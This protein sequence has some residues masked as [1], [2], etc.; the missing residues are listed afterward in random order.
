MPWIICGDLHLTDQARDNYRFGIFDWLRRQQEKYS[1]AAT[2]F[3]GDLTDQKDRHSAILVNKIVDELK[4]LKPPVFIDTGN[5]DY[6]RNPDNPF[7]KFLNHIEGI[8]FVTE[9][10]VYQRMAIIPHY[11]D[12]ASFDHAVFTVSKHSPLAFLV[13]QTFE[14]AIAETG[15]RLNGFSAS[16]I[17]L[18]RP[19][20]GVYAG[21]VHMPQTQGIIKY[22][23]CPYHVRFGD[24]FN[25]RVL[26]HVS[27]EDKN[28]QF[29]A[30]YKW[31]LKINDANDL[32]D[33]HNLMPEDQVKLVVELSREETVDWK[34]I[35][36][37]VLQA[38][39][40]LKLEVYGLKMTI[41]ETKQLKQIRVRGR[42]NAEIYD[43][44]CD[45]EGITSHIRKCGLWIL[46][47]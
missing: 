45:A 38:C 32:F 42:S 17:E 33:N 20:L 24:Q 7:F 27:G 14:G 39:K 8:T 3:A 13:H 43:S 41:T 16:P 44:F 4:K 35:K 9:P 28:L 37:S 5:H 25:P 31:S 22:I 40:E 15:I 29:Q 21:D 36:A 30:P 18:L 1:V 11:R 26:L 12:Q 2:F 10:K 47:R 34:K 46:R 19:P 23:G 6:C